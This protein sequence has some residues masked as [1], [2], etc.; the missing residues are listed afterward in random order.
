MYLDISIESQLCKFQ[1]KMSANKMTVSVNIGK[2]A[3]L[4]QGAPYYADRE[5]IK[6]IFI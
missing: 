2:I 3:D 1:I 6:G 5:T 4:R